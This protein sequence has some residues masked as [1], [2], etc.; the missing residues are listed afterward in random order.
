MAVRGF[1]FSPICEEFADKFMRTL[2]Q[3]DNS[4]SEYDLFRDFLELSAISIQNSLLPNSTDLWQ[5]NE[6]QYLSC[7]KRYNEEQLSLFSSM[8]AYLIHALIKSEYDYLGEVYM[9]VASNK[10]LGQFFTPFHVSEMMAQMSLADVES[11]LKSKNFI[12]INEPTCGCGSMIIAAIKVLKTKN[13]CLHK[14]IHFIGQDI[15]MYPFYGAYIQCSLL[16][17]SATFM[18]GDSLKIPDENVLRFETPM[19]VLYRKDFTKQNK[20]PILKTRI[21]KR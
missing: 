11:L 19:S 14:Q 20:L 7:T 12:T 4:K 6:R 10:F 9:Q 8:L 3:I 2:R 5:R 16:G 1:R 17:A 21:V 18:L 15:A 13:V